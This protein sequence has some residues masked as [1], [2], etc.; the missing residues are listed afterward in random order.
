MRDHPFT[1][2]LAETNRRSHPNVAFRAV[3]SLPGDSV[4]AVTKGNI[5]SRSDID[6]ASIEA[7]RTLKRR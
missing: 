5:I 1:V 3:L 6:F 7:Y 2:N 4:K